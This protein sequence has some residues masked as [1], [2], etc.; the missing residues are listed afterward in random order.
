MKRSLSVYLLIFFVS[1]CSFA[2]ILP[3]PIFSRYTNSTEKQIRQASRIKETEISSKQ[4][5]S[6]RIL[7]IT[8]ENGLSSLLEIGQK[9]EIYDFKT[10]QTFFIERIGGK[11]HA[12]IIPA[13]KTDFEFITENL[14]QNACYPV[15][16]LYNSSSLIPASLATYMHGYSDE[17]NEYYGHYCL[18]FKSSKMDETQKADYYHQKA[19]KLAKKYAKQL[20]FN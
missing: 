3:Y 2:A 4:T 20:L 11:S 16:V 12:D 5:Q 18:H 10:K 8:W 6:N 17:N 13:S 19:V 1:F 14:P 15:A 7:D 9:Y